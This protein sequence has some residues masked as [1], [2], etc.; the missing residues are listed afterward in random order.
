MHS[1]FQNLLNAL[2]NE[3]QFNLLSSPFVYLFL[4][5]CVD[6][7]VNFFLYLD[8]RQLYHL[9]FVFHLVLGITNLLIDV[10]NK[11]EESIRLVEI[12]VSLSNIILLFNKVAD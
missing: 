11:L 9:V 2:L 8:L 12:V 10:A 3:Q 5:F 4:G 7:F 6:L 1:L